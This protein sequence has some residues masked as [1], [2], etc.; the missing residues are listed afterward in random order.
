MEKLKTC[1]KCNQELPISYFNKNK[2]SKDG[3]IPQCKLC[4]KNYKKAWKK[5]NPEKFKAQKA[6]WQKAWMKRNPE[7]VKAKL[8]KFKKK[9]VPYS[10]LSELDRKV[11][12]ARV[13]AWQKANPEKRKAARIF[14]KNMNPEKELNSR[15]KQ[16]FIRACR[17]SNENIPQELIEAKRAHLQLV[18]K[19]KEK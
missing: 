10:S 17:I 19:I 16:Y 18:H 13:C 6:R 3:L 12:I 11:Q 1:S 2:K 4:R 8:N 15:A 5:N 9:K 7:K 14:W